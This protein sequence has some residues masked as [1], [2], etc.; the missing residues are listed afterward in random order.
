M[1]D[2][3]IDSLQLEPLTNHRMAFRVGN[4]LPDCKPS[5]LT[6]RHSYNETM[7]ATKEKMIQFLSEYNTIEGMSARVCIRL[8]EIIHYI[9]D[10][11]TFPHNTHYT[12]NMK[13]HCVYESDLKHQLRAFADSEAAKDIRARIKRFD[14]LEELISFIQKIHRWYMSKQRN[15][16]DDCRFAVYVCTTVV[17]TLFH[18]IQKRYEIWHTWEYTYAPVS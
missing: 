13:D 6:T 11:F 8:G 10:Y 9:A 16:Y 17:A 3:I 1:A 12:G 14:S 18:I 2:Q 4:V 5:F 7:D 15:I